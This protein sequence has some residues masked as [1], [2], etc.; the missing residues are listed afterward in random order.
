MKTKQKEQQTIK[1]KKNAKKIERASG[2]ERKDENQRRGR[3]VQTVNR[4]L[5]FLSSV[6]NGWIKRK[7]NSEKKSSDI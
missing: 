2:E 5:F 3:K 4:H 1:K 7:K 6:E